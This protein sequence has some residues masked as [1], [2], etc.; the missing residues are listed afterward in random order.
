MAI[1]QC[2]NGHYYDDAK[3]ASCPHCRDAAAEDGSTVSFAEEEARVGE[4]LAA[5][6]G[7]DERT[8]G[9]FQSRMKADPVV[10]WIVC[11]KGPE[12]GRDYRIHSGRNFIG[13]AYGMDIPIADDPAVSREKHCSIV[14]DPL[15][16]DFLLVPGEGTGTYVGDQILTAPVSLSDDDVVKIG[17]SVFVFVA[18]CKGERTWL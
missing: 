5:M 9:I 3:Y 10:A 14:F 4:K 13:R 17:D 16:G 8:V 15:H 2:E 7:S 6:V 11:T 1:V 12:R 18:F